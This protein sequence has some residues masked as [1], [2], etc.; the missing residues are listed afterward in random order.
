MDKDRKARILSVIERDAVIRCQYVNEKGEFCIIG[1]L[2]GEIGI[3]VKTELF[4]TRMNRRG[5]QDLVWLNQLVV[6]FGLNQYQ[7]RALQ[8]INGFVSDGGTRQ[9]HLRQHIEVIEKNAP[10]S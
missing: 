8:F 3:D 5:V 1:G 9:I 10:T 2:L 4:K 6:T 7:L